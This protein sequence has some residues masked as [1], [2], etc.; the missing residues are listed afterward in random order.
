M[1]LWV[2]QSGDMEA[3][4][5]RLNTTSHEVL[6]DVNDSNSF[7]YYSYESPIRFF[8]QDYGYNYKEIRGNQVSFFITHMREGKRVFEYY[9]R[10]ITQGEFA[11]MPSQL[12][13][14]YN[15][16]IWGYS[17]SNALEIISSE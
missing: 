4:N 14:M 3:I 13:A 12:S 11:V 16:E 10:A 8:W 6:S 9:A 1:P 17:D 5:E 7:V 15:P 2:S